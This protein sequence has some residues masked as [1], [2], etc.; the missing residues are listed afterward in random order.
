MASNFA[1]KFHITNGTVKVTTSNGT[2][3]SAGSNVGTGDQIRVYDNSGVLKFTYNVLIYG[4]TNGDG[5]V[6]AMDLLRVQ[7]D[8]LAVSKL[9]GS[10]SKAADTN[11]DGSVN[12]LDLLQVK[13]HILQ[14]K[15]IGQ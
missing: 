11:K 10:Y 7:K 4:D 15:S 6:T 9:S 3:K 8:I 2:E 12:G 5:Q 1:T 14:L 13:K